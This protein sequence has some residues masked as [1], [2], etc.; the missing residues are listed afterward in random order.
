MHINTNTMN[1]NTMNNNN[2]KIIKV[3]FSFGDDEY[4]PALL[5]Y[6]H[7]LKRENLCEGN[8]MQLEKNNATSTSKYKIETLYKDKEITIFLTYSASELIDCHIMLDDNRIPVK[9]YVIYNSLQ[10]EQICCDNVHVFRLH[11][12]IL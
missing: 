4:L 6:G 12:K 2:T 9:D 1:T 3:L 10:I 8:I 5:G 7:N 11:D